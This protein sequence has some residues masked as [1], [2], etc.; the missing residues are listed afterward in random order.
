[1]GF[2]TTDLLQEK[3]DWYADNQFSLKPEEEE[4]YF[5]EVNQITFL[6]HALEI[7]LARHRELSSL[8]FDALKSYLASDTRLESNK[9]QKE[10]VFYSML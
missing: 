3:H 9:P 8:R 2:Q 6:L 1:M 4:K 5:E 10:D 7:R